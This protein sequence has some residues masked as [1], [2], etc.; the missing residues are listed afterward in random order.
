MSF[1]EWKLTGILGRKRLARRQS[2]NEGSK[3]LKNRVVL[4]YTAPHMAGCRECREGGES[5]LV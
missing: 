1:R 4:I 2:K 3:R 5:D